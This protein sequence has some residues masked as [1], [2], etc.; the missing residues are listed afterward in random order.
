MAGGRPHKAVTKSLGLALSIGESGAG[1]L[2]R[3]QR[4]AARVHPANMKGKGEPLVP[5]AAPP[6]FRLL[7]QTLKGCDIAG[8]V[9]IFGLRR[10]PG[11]SRLPVER[12]RQIVHGAP[13]QARQ[14]Q[15]SA[16]SLFFSA[17]K[18]ALSVAAAAARRRTR[19]IFGAEV[20]AAATSKAA[21]FFSFVPVGWSRADLIRTP[22]GRG[23]SIGRRPEDP[24]AWPPSPRVRRVEKRG[25]RL[26]P[27]RRN[28]GRNLPR[29]GVSKRMERGHATGPAWAATTAP[30]DCQ[31]GGV[32]DSPGAG[33]DPAVEGLRGYQ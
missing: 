24:H 27:G 21:R 9:R 16:P 8:L 3:L 10:R 25:A 30:A 13:H 11:H 7:Q 20:W 17:G 5:V 6:F 26:I 23:A 28:N 14:G 31:G 33:L 29:A 15:A 12:M 18:R 4:V 1:P 2:R 32:G 22:P 19:Q